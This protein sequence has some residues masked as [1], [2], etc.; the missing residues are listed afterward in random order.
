M[1]TI[2]LLTTILL[3]LSLYAQRT[4][5]VSTTIVYRAEGYW[6]VE[7]AKLMAIEQAKIAAVDS[8][9]G[10]NV[11]SQT[12]N[13][14]ELGNGKDINEFVDIS[15]TDVRGRW[16]KTLR[17]P[18]FGR[19]WYEGNLLN[20]TVTVNGV[21]REIT[22]STIDCKVKVLCDGTDKDNARQDFND[23]N[24]IYLSFT[25]PV[26]GYLVVYLVDDKLDAYCALPYY[27]QN[28]GA[29]RIEA[30]REYVFFSRDKALESDIPYV[31]EY[32]LDTDK[33]VETN[34][35][36]V[37]FSPNEFVKPIGKTVDSDRPRQLSWKEFNSWLGKCMSRDKDMVGE[38][39]IF[40]HIRKN[41]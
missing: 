23:G 22:P 26:D 29:Y 2:T 37:I 15:S 30:G 32:N 13:I 33:D 21:V 8:V 34:L 9:F 28:V 41:D 39:P 12:R 14:V 35:L 18:E 36:Y 38:K 17:E 1:R 25:A 11:I 10:T 19:I 4:E 24:N 7:Q 3:A 16:I 40:L 5:K 20:V 31:E 6:S 27:D